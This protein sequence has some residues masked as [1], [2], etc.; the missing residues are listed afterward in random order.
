MKI[1]MSKIS[2]VF[3]SYAKYSLYKI[4]QHITLWKGNR[5]LN[6]VNFN[7]I[8]QI[9]LNTQIEFYTYIEFS[10]SLFQFIRIYLL[11]P[12]NS[13]SLIQT[14]IS[15]V[16]PLRYAQAI[17]YVPSFNLI[18]HPLREYIHLYRHSCNAYTDTLWN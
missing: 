18:C 14:F 8:Q 3:L 11:Q 10:L 6:F 2:S 1:F 5:E 15:N 13:H 7:V 9:Y 17:V 12:R 16:F 4:S